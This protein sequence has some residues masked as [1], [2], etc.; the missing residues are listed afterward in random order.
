MR[1]HG[2]ALRLSLS[3]RVRR[4]HKQALSRA[5]TAAIQA[6]EESMVPIDERPDDLTVVFLLSALGFVLSLAVIRMAPVE[7]LH[8]MTALEMTRR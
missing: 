3:S 1:A 2:R 5:E 7:A 8:W 4:L 6:L